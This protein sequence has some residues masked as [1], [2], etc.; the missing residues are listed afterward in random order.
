MSYLFESSILDVE[1]LGINE[2]E[3][4]SVLFSER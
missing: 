2:V 4:F 1:F 3:Q